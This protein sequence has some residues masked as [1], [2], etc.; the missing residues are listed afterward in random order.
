MA[1]IRKQL[2]SQIDEKK[3]QD[4]LLTFILTKGNSK[5]G[6]ALVNFIYSLAKSAVSTQVT[7]TKVSDFILATAYRSSLWMNNDILKLK[8]TK[9]YLADHVEALILYF[10][11]FEFVTLEEMVKHLIKELKP[12]KLKHP[13]EEEQI[14]VLSFKNLLN[15]LKQK[16]LE[17][18]DDS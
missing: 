16:F 15:E 17:A 13:R 12:E 2:R 1:F 3:T 4:S 10:W 7:G 11:V 5:L 18:K 14:A 8:G 6:D 9:G